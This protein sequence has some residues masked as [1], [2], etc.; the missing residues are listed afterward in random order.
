MLRVLLLSSGLALA[1]SPGLAQSFTT[2]A[3]VRPIL[4]IQKTG[5]AALRDWQGKDLVYFTA[6][7][8]WRC[9]LSAI[10]YGINDDPVETPHA[11]EPCYEGTSAPNALLENDTFP[12]YAEF[13]AGSVTSVTVTVTYDD[14]ETST[15]TM[16][17]Q[18]ILLP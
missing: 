17:A 10:H 14:G 2:A 8:A 3:E 6:V 12:I 7:L 1:A 5:W 16:T 4:E 18:S 9:G 15:S 11:M 13:P